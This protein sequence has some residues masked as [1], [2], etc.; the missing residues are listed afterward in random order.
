[1]NANEPETTT[2]KFMNPP[3]DCRDDKRQPLEID[4]PLADPRADFPPSCRSKVDADRLLSILD[5]LA[6]GEG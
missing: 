3:A 5:E 6:G 2:I 1:M 4:N